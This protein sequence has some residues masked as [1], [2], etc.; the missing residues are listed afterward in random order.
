MLLYFILEYLEDHNLS[1]LLVLKHF[2]KITLKKASSTDNH[3][4]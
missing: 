4:S 3:P 1:Y 2:G